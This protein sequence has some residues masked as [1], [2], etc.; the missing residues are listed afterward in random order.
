MYDRGWNSG[1]HLWAYRAQ[2]GKTSPHAYSGAGMALAGLIMGYVGM[3]F[4]VLILP[5]ML[6]PALA[7]AKERAQSINCMN[8]MKQIGLAY[9]TWALDNND[10]YPWNLSVTNGGTKELTAPGAVHPD[11]NPIQFEVLSNELYTPKILICP[12]DMTNTAALQFA[13]LQSYNVSYQL[14]TGSNVNDA[15]QP[16][17]GLLSDSRAYADVRRVSAIQ[18]PYSKDTALLICRRVPYSVFRVASID[19]PRNDH[20]LVV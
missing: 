20:S 13:N 5:A 4:T 2:P 18:T 3:A 14:N 19:F 15:F 16:G 6:L 1:G 12:A 8:N 7:K 17:A 10:Q 9:R 11:H